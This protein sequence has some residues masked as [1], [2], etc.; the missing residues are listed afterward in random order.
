MRLVDFRFHFS[1]CGIDGS[2][3]AR[4]I[5]FWR[6]LLAS[7]REWTDP[8]QHNGAK[9]GEEGGQSAEG[10]NLLLCRNRR[11]LGGV[12]LLISSR[13]IVWFPLSAHAPPPSVPP[14]PTQPNKIS[15]P[16]R[17]LCYSSFALLS[18]I[19]LEIYQMKPIIFERSPVSIPF[20]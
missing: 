6:F 1:S 7:E 8:A 10:M 12:P 19:H 16:L 3:R 5:P 18:F 17:T 13:P 11:L 20:Q 9:F 14:P 4:S 15:S 2:A